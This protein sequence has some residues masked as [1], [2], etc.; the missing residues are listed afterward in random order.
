V[1]ETLRTTDEGLWTL[2][3][4]EHGAHAWH[5]AAASR[6]RTFKLHGALEDVHNAWWQQLL[7]GDQLT[8]LLK[9][10]RL[11]TLADFGTAQPEL[12]TVNWDDFLSKRSLDYR[13]FLLYVYDTG[14]VAAPWRRNGEAW[15][16]DDRP[17]VELT[18]RDTR[19]RPYLPGL[20]R[21]SG[22]RVVELHPYE[23]ELITG[24]DEPA[25]STATGSWE[26]SDR[27]HTR[28]PCGRRRRQRPPLMDSAARTGR[29]QGTSRERSHGV[30]HPGRVPRRGRHLRRLHDRAPCD[31]GHLRRSDAVPAI[32]ASLQDLVA[33]RGLG[34]P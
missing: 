23:D 9:E 24:V 1:T 4:S 31:G 11:I 3:G 15:R 33:F 20:L 28:T 25:L 6:G 7:T 22:W 16:E 8:S 18:Y 10:A 17:T 12:L 29:A 27:L 19:R 32:C 26:R 2:W 14:T 30:R 21:A 34:R 13:G 5:R